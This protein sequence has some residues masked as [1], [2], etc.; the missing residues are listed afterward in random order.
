MYSLRSGDVKKEYSI[1]VGEPSYLGT[2][3]IKVYGCYL[4]YLGRNLIP[5]LITNLHEDYTDE[6]DSFKNLFI[7]YDVDKKEVIH[8]VKNLSVSPVGSGSNFLVY[9]KNNLVFY[10]S[11][12]KAPYNNIIIND[13]FNLYSKP[14]EYYETDS[15]GHRM[16]FTICNGI[17]VSKRFTGGTNSNG[18]YFPRVSI[19][20]SGYK[21]DN[22]SYLENSIV[23]DSNGEKYS[24][25]GVLK[26][27]DVNCRYVILYYVHTKYYTKAIKIFKYDTDSDRLIEL[28]G[29]IKCE[30]SNIGGSTSIGHGFIYLSDDRYLYI[31]SSEWSDLCIGRVDMSAS[32]YKYEFLGSSDPGVKVNL[33]G[34]EASIDREFI[35]IHVNFRTNHALVKFNLNTREFS[36]FSIDEFHESYYIFTSQ[37][38]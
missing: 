2:T 27:V 14:N 29:L 34:I 10:Y 36:N 32:E 23:E 28:S 16:N 8:K 5:I 18:V 25:E 9:D 22:S 1:N 17:L 7:V 6:Y 26:T 12:Y 35:Y 24:Y 38:S 3:T 20:Q 13:I 11:G 19:D 15:F 33:Y 4:S 30:K 37:S 21:I 31:I